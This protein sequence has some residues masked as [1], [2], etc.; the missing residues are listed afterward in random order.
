MKKYIVGIFVILAM[1][2]GML[3]AAD[4]PKLSSDSIKEIRDIQLDQSRLQTQSLQ[5]QVQY[6]A[7]QQELQHDTTELETSKERALAAAKL[8]PKEYDVD[9]DKLVF[10]TKPKA[11]AVEKK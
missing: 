1:T 2:V 10:I 5:L 7:I 4:L 11:A 9:L 3:V 8:D 6:N